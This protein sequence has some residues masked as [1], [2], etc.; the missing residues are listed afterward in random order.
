MVHGAPAIEAGML[1]LLV[2]AEEV[3]A[4]FHA[5][6]FPI[7]HW[8]AVK[9]AQIES[10]HLRQERAR[11]ERLNRE[12]RQVTLGSLLVGSIR[13]LRARHG[14]DARRLAD[15]LEELG[16]PNDP[17][18]DEMVIGVLLATPEGQARANEWLDRGASDE[19][20]VDEVRTFAEIVEGY[21]ESLIFW[22]IGEL[23]EVTAE[24]LDTPD[25]VDADVLED[26]REA[27]R[28]REFADAAQPPL[29][30]WEVL[31]LA[32]SDR[33]GVKRAADR[34]QS[35][36]VGEPA[37]DLNDDLIR[38]FE[39]LLEIRTAHGDLARGLRE[40]VRSL[41]LGSFSPST[42]DLALGFVMASPE[43]RNRA[44]AWLDLPDRYRREAAIRLEGVIGKAQHYQ[45]ALAA[46]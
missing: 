30:S 36:M 38:F 9:M 25:R 40:Y 20:V 26:L 32:L 28:L 3:R 6:R 37:S 34:L 2:S 10:D 15:L 24:S 44:R 46:A 39:R 1:D 14:A 31:S 21:R 33:S 7:A 4:L 19:R 5:L 27:E 18:L 42:L 17:M 29:E 43:G 35:N 11:L 45:R 13:S 8:E 16:L 22:R 41:P 23:V 12:G